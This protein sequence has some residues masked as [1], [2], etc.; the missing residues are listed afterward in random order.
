VDNNPLYTPSI[1]ID[2][3]DLECYGEKGG[4]VHKPEAPPSAPPA[5]GPP[6][7]KLKQVGSGVGLGVG[8]TKEAPIEID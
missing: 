2:S 6:K 4:R 3:D 7:K 1:Q 8:D 5:K